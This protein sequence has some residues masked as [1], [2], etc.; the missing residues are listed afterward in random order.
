MPAAPFVESI[1]TKNLGGMPAR[2]NSLTAGIIEGEKTTYVKIGQLELENFSGEKFLTLNDLYIK[3]K[4]LDIVQGRVG[5][6]HIE[7][8]DIVANL[9]RAK[10]GKLY[11]LI[12]ERDN[13]STSPEKLGIDVSLFSF[14]SSTHN[15][16]G[17]VYIDSFKLDG[18]KF[19]YSDIGSG[20]GFKLNNIRINVSSD[21]ESK[22]TKAII[23]TEAD[24]K[25]SN[26]IINADIAINRTG[27]IESGAVEFLNLRPDAFSGLPGKMGEI[28][29]VKL[30]L[31]GAIKVENNGKDLSFNVTSGDGKI[32]NKA[33]FPKSAAIKSAAIK[34]VS[35]LDFNNIDVR[36]FNLAL[37]SGEMTGSLKYHH[38]K[39]ENL[40]EF[41]AGLK[42]FMVNDLDTYWPLPLEKSVRDWVTGN[43]NDCVIPEADI[44]MQYSNLSGK[45]GN[46]K[47]KNPFSL[48]LKSQVK[49]NNCSLVYMP[50]HPRITGASGVATFTNDGMNID[51]T[52]GKMLA[53]SVIKS[54]NVSIPDFHAKTN[55]LE[56]KVDV[57]S[58]LS[59][60]FEYLKLPEFDIPEDAGLNPA[61]AA[62]DVAGSVKLS[63]P[64][65]HKLDKNDVKHTITAVTSNASIQKIAGK[66][67]LSSMNAEAEIVDGVVK[68]GGHGLINGI[69]MD[70]NFASTSGKNAGFTVTAKSSKEKTS[71]KDYGISGLDFLSGNPDVELHYTKSSA[72]SVLNIAADLKDAAINFKP[73]SFVKPLGHSARLN[74]NVD[75]R[76]DRVKISDFSLNGES[77]AIQGDIVLADGSNKIISANLPVVKYAGNDFAFKAA[78]EDGGYNSYSVVG[79]SINLE[80]FMAEKSDEASKTKLK[81]DIKDAFSL[82]K[83]KAS[84]LN[85]SIECSG[86]ICPKINGAG[87]FPNGKTFAISTM[88][89][90]GALVTKAQ[91]NDAGY[92]LKFL[93]VFNGM[94]GGDLDY[95]A[96][97]M[98]DNT[99]DCLA[100]ITDFKI[101]TA[102][103]L[104]KLLSVASITGVLDGLNT[105]SGISFGKLEM[106]FKKTASAISFQNARI[107]GPSIGLAA[108]GVINSKTDTMNVEGTI[109]PAYVLNTLLDK[110]PLI[111]SALTG[112]K[113]RGIFAFSFT[114]KGALAS[115]DVSV[116]PLSA[117]TPGFLRE[118]FGIFKSNEDDVPAVAPAAPPAPVVPPA[119]TPIPQP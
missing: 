103:A 77:V 79:N 24:Y 69:P 93:G 73:A 14:L 115:P 97:T 52:S 12:G 85:L 23:K 41:K 96:K 51:V 111:G 35:S 25:K 117:I 18:G 61:L 42:D 16:G 55:I 58:S 100:E 84:N 101:T 13:S 36:D 28:S 114:A 99:Q 62:G 90:G 107:S 70:M 45:F 60:V 65:L 81:L 116:N 5:L 48:A 54:G 95:S 86:G 119:S 9:T 15:S 43:I 56:V 46:K 88:E 40:I 33:I 113:G 82:E 110:V 83:S 118:I 64:L 98:I 22:S 68:I 32:D 94:D 6:G 37:S 75:I 104:A 106:P 109:V 29:G 27:N 19:Y 30:S 102:P 26:G 108:T 2:I 71:A 10:D 38:S 74:M 34:G 89:Q 78:A 39:M 91:S 20:E 11:L 92:M 53:D 87:V 47:N 59:D 57:S 7:L 21:S 17:G 4:P 8:Q 49:F 112:G 105:K 72:A 31:D 63:I 66:F 67:T 80:P 76:D 50:E 3:I 44:D 1:I